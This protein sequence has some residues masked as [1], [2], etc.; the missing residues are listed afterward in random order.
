MAKTKKG[1][2]RPPPKR[3]TQAVPRVPRAVSKA[4]NAVCGLTDPFCH[5]AVAV[6]YPDESMTRTITEQLRLDVPIAADANGNGAISFSASV[7][8]PYA[9][10]TTQAANGTVTWAASTANTLSSLFSTYGGEYRVTSIGVRAMNT[11][12][13]TNSSGYMI[14][15][16]KKYLGSTDVTNFAPSSFDNATT[17]ALTHGLQVNALPKQNG[18]DSRLFQTAGLN[19]NQW[20]A[21]AFIW[22]GAPVGAVVVFEFII[23]YEFILDSNAT[24]NTIGTL[25]RPSPVANPMLIKAANSVSSSI[26]NFFVGTLEKFSSKIAGLAVGAVA[27]RI[28]GPTA[29]ATA[30]SMIANVD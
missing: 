27:A 24:S 18:P 12:S 21:I 5:H 25:A 28:G 23:N 8:N 15:G 16:T 9:L 30:Y 1:S 4:A 26:G 3:R 29:G 11:A 22:T 14:M 20:E 7:S 10:P 13:A 2:R 6:Q 17:I 19:A